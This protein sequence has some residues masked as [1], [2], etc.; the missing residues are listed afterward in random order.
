MGWL[1]VPW[2]SDLRLNANGRPLVLLSRPSSLR[3]RAR[4]G[5]RWPSRGVGLRSN[6]RSISSSAHRWRPQSCLR[7][8]QRRR[9]KRTL[10]SNCSRLTAHLSDAPML[11]AQGGANDWMTP[12]T[13]SSSLL[14]VLRLVRI[15]GRLPEAALCAGGHQS[16]PNTR[17]QR[18]LPPGRTDP[19][20]ARRSAFC[21]RSS[22][23]RKRRAGELCDRP[24]HIAPLRA[25]AGFAITV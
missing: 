5:L 6:L 18:A 4:S 1:D 17:R 7:R 9:S 14:R 24:P 25:P 16:A 3:A 22:A 23:V 20:R 21:S 8:T 13:L 10:P 11:I 12:T 2:P 19:T 15:H